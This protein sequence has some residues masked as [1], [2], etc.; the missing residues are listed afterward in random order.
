MALSGTISTSVR[1]HWKL[2]VSW[3][4][5]Q[6][7]SNNT[8]TITAKMYW[9]AVD[10]YGAIYSD[11]SK[12]GSIYIDGTWYNF[13]GAGLARLSP[14][15]KKLIAT[16]SKTVKHNADGTKSFSLG[17][18][19]DPDVD[20]G[21]HQGKISLSNKTFTLNTI[22]RK[23]TMSSGG[24]FTAG[25][26]R[27]ISISRA[28]SSFSHKLYIDIKDS[29]GNWV[30]I[31][32]INFSK[33]ETSK[34]TSFS[35]DEK[36]TIFRALNERTSAQI[37]YNLHTLS[38]SNDIGY[39]TYYGT[40]N[41]PKL[42]V[43]NK[44]NGQ[45]GSSNSVYIDQSL[46]IDLTRYDSEFDHKVQVICG[47]FTKEFNGVGYTQSWTP[48]ASEQSTLYGILNNVISKSAT[49]RVYTYY[50][51]VRVG[52]T[53]Y[54]MTYY[55]RSSNNKPTF[56]D[57][58]IFYTDTNP[59]TL[60]IT[61]DDQYI[62][63]GVSTLRVEIPVESKAV[64]V[65]GA[66][67][68][69]YSITVNGVTKNVNYSSTGTVSADFGTINSAS[70]ATVSIKAI[71]SRGLST[72]VTKVVKIVPYAYPS[73][74]TTAKRTN[75][76]ERTTTLTLR[77]GLSPIAVNGSNR[78]ALESARYRY[79]LTDATTYGSWN[80]FTVSGFPSYSATNVSLDLDENETWDVQVEVSDSLGVTTKTISVSAGRP[81]MFLDAQ[82]KAVGIGDFPSNEYELKIN[83]RI[84]FGATFWASDEGEGFGAI[85][86]NNSDISNANGIYFADVAQNMNGE[87]LMF[88]KSGAQYG[89]KDINDYDNLMVR[90]GVL[91]LNAA[92]SEMKLGNHLQMQN[93]DI[94]NVNHITI[95][96]PGGGEGIEWL[97]G[98]G[99]KIVEA[100]N[101]LS[102][103]GGPLQF[104][105]RNTRQA[106]IS[107]AG[108][109]YIAGKIFKGESGGYTYFASQEQAC[110][111]SDAPGGASIR[112]HVDGAGGRVWSNDIYNRTYDKA[113]N[114]YI[115]TE[116]T[117]GR[118]TSASKYK[119][120]I[121]KVDTELLPSKILE[122]NPKSWYNKTA[123]ELY[124][125]QL[126]TPEDDL[127]SGEEVEEDIPFIERSYGLIAEDLVDA[128]LDM[129]VSWGKADENGQREVEGIE[130]DRLWVLLIPLVR[131]QKQQIEELQERIAQLELSN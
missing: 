20:L 53:D 120:F 54:G 92:G 94:R 64:A 111:T 125:D 106:T 90:D 131:E 7:I 49:V 27:T 51:G 3:S 62:I 8:S 76:Y 24:D 108:N 63:Q 15:Q 47:S 23:S 52:S 67:M 117:L 95:N 58:G 126:G 28:S 127:E 101:D 86:L 91:Y 56:T 2:S 45:A 59:T 16:K 80:N 43:V 69:S 10:G 110:L 14:N 124:A 109:I 82:R 21:G 77:G 17:G 114:V 66:T 98:S 38:G 123:V 11:V 128:G 113:S 18:W 60:N 104:A 79:K 89:S 99:W 12:S 26:D 42:S 115:T 81:I 9:E 36:K 70:N 48:T 97:G 35:T 116:G 30:N 33:S 44:L 107:T 102:N 68:K 93:Y 40:A 22:P 130:Y 74:T 103:T 129:F 100:P 84:V 105:T 119:V 112:V 37:R 83:G 29:G 50:N 32:S 57:A 121:K 41:R 25:S 6:S 61:A 118:A 5:T 122:L 88:F 19:F 4:A 55:V 72:A 87:G 65:N 73:V 34:S 78:N 75:G 71:D 39:N 46:T 85:D 13:S 31:K 1:T 96:D